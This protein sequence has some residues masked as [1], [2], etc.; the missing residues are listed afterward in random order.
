MASSMNRVPTKPTKR[1]PA[2]R[3]FYEK[4]AD[5]ATSSDIINEARSSLRTLRT[6]RPHTPKDDRRTFFGERAGHERPPSSFSLGARHLDGNDS[7]PSSRDTGRPVSGKRLAPLEMTP[8]LP[9]PGPV[10]PPGGDAVPK[11][12]KPPSIVTKRPGSGSRRQR[13]KLINAVSQEGITQVLPPPL[14][15]QNSMPT[16]PPT[17]PEES[18]SRRVHSGPKERTRLELQHNGEESNQRS[19]S[20]GTLHPP[21]QRER[22]SSGGSCRSESGYVSDR[23][24]SRGSRTGSGSKREEETAEE[25]LYW[26]T[27]VAPILE[28]VLPPHLGSVDSPVVEAICKACD[29]LYDAL[30][31][32]NML[33]RAAKRRNVALKTI[34]KLSDLSEPRVL[35]RAARL[36]LALHVSGGNLT[37]VCKLVFKISKEEK[38]DSLF[39]ENNILDLVV[40][41]LSRVE[42]PDL[43]EALVY[44]LGALKFLSG[45]TTVSQRLSQAPLIQALA[46][47]LASINEQ[48][49]KSGRLSKTGVNLLVQVTG[50]LRNLADLPETRG[51]FL[52]R[53]II[54]E[55]CH[56]MDVYIAEGELMLNVSRLFSKLTLSQDCCSALVDE[57]TCFQCLLNLLDKYP[58]RSDITVRVCFILG[59]L[60]VR[61]D[62]CRYCLFNAPN[63]MDI[64]VSVFR[65]YFAKDLKG[66]RETPQESN[67]RS[68]S[69][70][71]SPS[72]NKTEDVLIKLIRIIANLSINQDIGP[73]IAANETCVDLDYKDINIS[74]ELVLNAV[75]TINNLSYYNIPGSAITERQMDISRLLLKLLMTD[76]M[77]GMIE[78]SRVFGNLSRAIEV[79]DYITNKK[80]D[81]MMMTLLDAGSREIVYTSCGV[82]INLTA[83]EHRRPLLKQEGGIQK[84]IEVMRDFGRSDWQLA[85]MVCM[86]LWNYS[87]KIE[88]SVETFGEQETADLIDLLVDLLDEE[89][90]LDTPENADW[91]EETQDF[92]RSYWHSEFCPVASQLLQ[93]VERCQS[94]LVPI[95]DES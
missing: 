95:G 54:P 71:N 55:L 87:E 35:L 15:R 60:T 57:A 91:D 5:K 33:G 72:I 4:P 17:S 86:T 51:D 27:K 74:E 36:I 77:A 28:R 1:K 43:G 93:R 64:L 68:S 47:L 30:E 50:I 11:L 59:N 92:M 89:T 14:V 22:A 41:L 45:N 80:V 63:A 29:E 19:S 10:S 20:A 42:Y 18:Q 26:N 39:L 69:G 13:A 24:A 6:N 38:H 31:E 46:K 85:G 66:L 52:T 53:G 21:G 49:K 32:G 83:D 84:L 67:S 73:L 40:S 58:E 9:P 61:N 62:D 76:N 25:A 7:R 75:I 37:S 78:A 48:Q 88:S 94:A 2:E 81:E 79:R 34:F 90:A 12:P 65:G 23:A 44:C 70:E 8:N 56:I 16:K 3:A 82:L